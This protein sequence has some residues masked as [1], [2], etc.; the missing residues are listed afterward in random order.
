[1]SAPNNEAVISFLSNA[2]CVEVINKAEPKLV[3]HLT[4]EK[5][6]DLKSDICRIAKLLLYGGYYFDAD[7]SS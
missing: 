7:F 3:K 1:M 2:D 6:G 5:K 4:K